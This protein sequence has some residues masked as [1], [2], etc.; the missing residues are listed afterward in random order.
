MHSRLGTELILSP[1]V[2]SIRLPRR[3]R[4]ALVLVFLFLGSSRFSFADPVRVTD[5]TG[6]AVALAQP[7]QRIVSLAPS[8]TE[9][10]Y[11]LGLDAE[12]AGV[13]D[14]CDYPPAARSKPRVGGI[15]SASVEAVV[16]R[17]PDLILALDALN[18]PALVDALRRL[19]LPVASLAS[20]SVAAIQREIG[21]IGALAGRAAAARALNDSIRARLE[22]VEARVASAAPVTVVYVLWHEPLMTIGRSSFIADLIH[23]AGGRLADEHS[24]LPYYRLALEAVLEQ[25]P[26]V[27]LIPTEIGPTAVA[28]QRQYW[29]RWPQLAAVRTGRIYSVDSD[30]IHRPGPRI[31]AGVELLAQRLHPELFP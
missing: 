18:G 22:A 30:L 29:E 21:M 2:F 6:H 23:R 20:D 8:I 19:G 1:S 14:A 5:A 7:A 17:R 16:A 11:A 13:T 24:P 25:N 28:L 26:A 9:I 27:I 3:L 15:N 4:A 10:L 31:A 12:I